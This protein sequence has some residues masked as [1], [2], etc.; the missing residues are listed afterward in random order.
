MVWTTADV[1]HTVEVLTYPTVSDYGREEPDY[2]AEP[3][4]VA[5]H[6]VELQPGASTELIA[7]RRDAT[8]V[9]W[10]VFVPTSSVPA[11]VELTDKTVIRVNGDDVCQV[12]GRPLAWID[13]GPLDHYLVSLTDWEGG[14]E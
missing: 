9:R 13:G 8:A 3:T 7:Q 11:G 14:A 12:D 2:S 6:G 4:A 5:L 10:T 1:R